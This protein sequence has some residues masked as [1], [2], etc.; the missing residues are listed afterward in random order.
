MSRRGRRANR[1]ALA[2]ATLFATVAGTAC[3]SSHP[4]DVAAR[5]KLRPDEMVEFDFQGRKIQLDSVLIGHDSISGIPWHNPALCCTRVSYATKEIT[6][7]KLTSFPSLGAITVGI[8]AVFTGFVML[9]A[10]SF[11]RD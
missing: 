11:P 6:S 3:V 8:L 10:A 1:R 2:S 5:T 7:P 9:F 4:V